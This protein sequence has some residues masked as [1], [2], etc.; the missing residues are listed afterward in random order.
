MKYPPKGPK[1]PRESGLFGV[2]PPLWKGMSQLAAQHL[3]RAYGESEPEY[4]TDDLR[5]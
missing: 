1:S 4:T 3:S 2:A 5:Q